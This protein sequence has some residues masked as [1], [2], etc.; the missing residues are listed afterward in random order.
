[1]KYDVKTPVSDFTGVVGSVG[2]AMGHALVDSETHPAE[3]AYFQS[4]GYHVSPVGEAEATAEPDAEPEPDANATEPPAGDADV[5]D[6]PRRSGSTEAWRA[7]AQS[8]GMSADE[9]GALSRDQ[10]AERYQA[11]E[12][13][14]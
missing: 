12:E 10:L 4:A 8:Q 7:Y 9:A 13:T 5:V 14:P 2:F 1:M 6:K 11:P 3:L